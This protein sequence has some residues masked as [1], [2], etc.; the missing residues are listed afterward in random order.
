MFPINDNELVLFHYRDGLDDSRLG[1]IAVALRASESLRIRYACLC[2]LL[3]GAD[4]EVPVPQEGFEQ[5]LWAGL[6]RR[7][8]NLPSRPVRPGAI[9]RIRDRLDRVFAPRL[10]WAGGFAMALL[11]ALATGFLVGRNG[12]QQQMA[13]ESPAA[14]SKMADRIL[15]VYVAGHLRATEGVLLTAA[16]D[17]GGELLAGNRELA[18]SLVES[19]RLYAAAAARSGNLR[20]ADFLRQLEPVLLEVANRPATST[21]EDRQGLRDYLRNTDLLFQVRATESRIDVASKRSL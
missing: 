14:P 21:V 10:I 12:A 19:N 4:A 3:K 11:I 8:A 5:R 20:L 18:Q 2:E 15:D 17:D 1:E 16:N 13:S 7:M 9:A 6:D